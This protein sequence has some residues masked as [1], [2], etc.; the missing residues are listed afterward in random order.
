MFKNRIKELTEYTKIPKTK[1]QENHAKNSQTKKVNINIL[2]KRNLT[3]LN[4]LN[5]IKS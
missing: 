2:K 4:T 3:K 5:F 1:P